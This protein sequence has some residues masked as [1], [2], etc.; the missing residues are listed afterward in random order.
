MKEFVLDGVDTCTSAGA[1]NTSFSF[2][3]APG[4]MIPERK[5][6]TKDGEDVTEHQL[7]SDVRVS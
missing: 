6:F 4:A 1:E 3:R 5:E 2:S 7:R